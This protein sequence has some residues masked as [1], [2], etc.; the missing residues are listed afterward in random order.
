MNGKRVSI[1]AKPSVSER[2]QSWIEQGNTPSAAAPLRGAV[3]TARLTIDITPELRARIKVSA[4]ARG[5]TVV[6]LLRDLLEREFP[7]ET[8]AMR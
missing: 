4:F 7:D 1:S 2:A 5:K 6:E 8:G 3:Y